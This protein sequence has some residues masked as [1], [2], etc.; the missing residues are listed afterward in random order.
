MSVENV[1]GSMESLAGGIIQWS[2]NIENQT[3]EPATAR[4]PTIVESYDS[5]V[6]CDDTSWKRVDSAT[7]N[8]LETYADDYA[9]GFVDADQEAW[10]IVRQRILKIDP[11]KP[12]EEID[13]PINLNWMWVMPQGFDPNTILRI[14]H[15]GSSHLLIVCESWAGVIEIPSEPSEAGFEPAQIPTK[16]NITLQGEI[17]SAIAYGNTPGEAIN[18]TAETQS[19][20]FGYLTALLTLSSSIQMVVSWIM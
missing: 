17:F 18:D 13:T 7:G 5:Y 4:E 15:I 2:F 6:I 19:L 14:E 9:V 20:F 10:H 12:I 16:W 3:G 11:F 1:D 8:I